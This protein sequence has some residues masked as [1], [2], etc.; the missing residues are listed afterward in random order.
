MEASPERRSV[1]VSVR[2]ELIREMVNRDGGATIASLVRTLNVSPATV[3]RD[4]SQLV[5]AGTL[6]RVRGGVRPTDNTPVQI[7]DF[8]RRRGQARRAKDAMAGAAANLVAPGATVFLDASTTTLAVAQRLDRNPPA[9][10]TLVTNSPAITCELQSSA[11]RTIVTPGELDT[12]GRLILG[13]WTVEFLERLKLDLAFVSG[14]GIT[15]ERGLTTT[16]PGIAETVRAAMSV[17]DRTV[18][19][20]DSSKFGKNGLLSIAPLQA[21]SHVFVDD[22]LGR[23]IR[24]EYEAAGIPLVVAQPPD[25]AS[26]I[27]PDC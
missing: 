1:P 16:M 22:G 17:A 18:A 15:L 7:T 2:H 6:Q 9:E 8:E 27:S 5:S 10:L 12:R 14:V 13:P 20:A 24:S 23:E 4:L 21:F 25:R 19:I 26:G 3:H 11:I